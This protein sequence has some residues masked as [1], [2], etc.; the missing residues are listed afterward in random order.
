MENTDWILEALMAVDR[1][2]RHSNGAEYAG[3]VREYEHLE[4]LYEREVAG[5]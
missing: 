1:R 4:R 3:L 5:I 2:M